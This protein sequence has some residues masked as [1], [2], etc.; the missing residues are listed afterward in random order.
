MKEIIETLKREA[1]ANEYQPDIDLADERN[2]QMIDFIRRSKLKVKVDTPG[3]DLSAHSFRID[4]ADESFVLYVRFDRNFYT[5]A[6]Y[7]KLGKT[8]RYVDD[9]EQINKRLGIVLGFL[10]NLGFQR[11]V[12]RDLMMFE[13]GNGPISAGFTSSN[14]FAL[15]IE[16][17]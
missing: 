16:D 5:C 7:T 10:E 3:N 6:A 9:E 15:Y 4:F 14:L 8:R 2:D 1:E 13:L 11:V 12:A 17:S